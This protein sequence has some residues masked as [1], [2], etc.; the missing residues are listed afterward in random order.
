MKKQKKRRSSIAIVFLKAIAATIAIIAISTIIILPAM[1]QMGDTS[2]WLDKTTFSPG[3]RVAVHFTVPASFPTNAWIG[4]IPSNIP[5]GSETTNDQHD[6]A[7]QY[8]KGKTGGT[9]YFIVPRKAGSYDFRMHDRDDSGREVGSVSFTITGFME[10]SASLSL[11]KRGYYV[12]ETIKVTFTAPASFP[13]NAWVGIIPSD[14]PHGNETVN[15][16]HDIAYKY[17]E[18]MTSGV[19][20]FAVPSTPGS[21]DIRMHDTDSG[22]REITSVSFTVTR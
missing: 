2:L 11:D 4:I 15:D 3:E 7:Y 14:V 22:G 8:L 20:S 18:G 17:L 9:I 10:G 19:L 6:V 13:R 5:H 16:Q 1:A 12:G 21:Y